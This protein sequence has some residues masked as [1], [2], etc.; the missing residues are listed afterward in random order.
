MS[1]PVSFCL[2]P[3]RALDESKGSFINTI[4]GTLLL[5]RHRCL[6][7]FLSPTN[8][9]HSPTPPPPPKQPEMAD[10]ARDSILSRA[11]S[12]GVG[13]PRAVH[14][15]GPKPQAGLL[16]WTYSPLI[17]RHFVHFQDT[18]VDL[19]WRSR[20]SCSDCTIAR[21]TVSHGILTCIFRAF[22]PLHYDHI[23]CNTSFSSNSLPQPMP[24][25]HPK[26]PKSLP[27]FL[28]CI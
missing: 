28:N 23:T 16:M 21:R 26:H 24:Y 13:A 25:P 22:L 5:L 12:A 19:D 6:L 3:K 9:P 20:S 14:G 1:L 2:H 17:K 7:S 8:T 18:S 4:E 11:P 15:G 27:N 10:R